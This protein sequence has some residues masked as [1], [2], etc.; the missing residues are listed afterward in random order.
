MACVR[1]TLICNPSSGRGVD[2]EGTATQLRDRG[3]DVVE[4]G[5]APD[6][7]SATEAERIVVVAG[8]GMVG[9]AAALAAERGVPLAVVPA[10][11]ANDFA[12]DRSLPTDN[13]EAAE[14]AATGA[15]TQ[16]MELAR[17]DGRPFVNAASAGLSTTAAARAKPFKQLLGPFAYVVGALVA[18][19]A[20]S[21]VRCVARVDGR[22]VFA[23]RAWQ[24]IVAATGAFG[25]G[26]EVDEAN[27]HD[28]RLDL[29]VM[30][31]TSRLRLPLMARSMRRGDLGSRAETTHAVGDE[32]E[33]DVPAGTPFNVD[34]ELV[35]S[36]RATVRFSA[37]RAAFDLVVPER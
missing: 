37:D 2:A 17:M 11:T 27:P 24:V 1:I 35:R 5:H 20:S 22:E 15:R 6:E 10:G 13:D 21:P 30:P 12:R 28:G 14:L 16:P 4:I 33:L 26:S 3:A 29:L 9:P 32:I 19:A 25:G 8:D 34:G 36:P 18:G 7:V 31:A 23:G